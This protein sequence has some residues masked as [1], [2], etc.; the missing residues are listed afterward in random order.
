MGA[1]SA[2]SAKSD[3]FTSLTSPKDKGDATQYDDA[4]EFDWAGEAVS[5]RDFWYLKKTTV[6]YIYFEIY[7]DNR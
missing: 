6:R 5:C 7:L 3:I 4:K 1:K 2:K